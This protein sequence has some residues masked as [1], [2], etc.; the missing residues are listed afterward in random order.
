[1]QLAARA[2]VGQ[3]EHIMGIL[4]GLRELPMLRQVQLKVWALLSVCCG[5]WIV[6]CLPGVS[7]DTAPG[8]PGLLCWGRSFLPVRF[9]ASGFF[10]EKLGKA[11]GMQS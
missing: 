5:L 4:R 8:L 1:M 3:L 6:D 11:F 10:R 9:A 7:L 2:R